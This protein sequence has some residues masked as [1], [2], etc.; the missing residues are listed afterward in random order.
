[1]KV[2]KLKKLTIV[3]YIALFVSGGLR[4]QG[5]YIPPDKPKLVIGIIV[6]Q[7]RY[8]QIERFR[9]RLVQNGIRRLLNEGTSFQNASYQYMLTE[10]APGHA[11]ISTG[12]EPAWHGIASDSWYLPLR[13]E[14]IYCTKDLNVKP[15]GVSSESGQHSPVNMQ[16]STFTDELKMASGK[17]AK[18]FSVG[19]KDHSVILSAGQINGYEEV[20]ELSLKII[21]KLNRIFY[22]FFIKSIFLLSI[23]R[24]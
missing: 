1:M 13:D 8:D 5:P 18:V 12:A 24:E 21:N 20:S 9:G 22:N 19:L 17:N 15:A 2:Q 23:K 6:E 16:A 11:T 4:G 3:L 14:H 10:S 7:L